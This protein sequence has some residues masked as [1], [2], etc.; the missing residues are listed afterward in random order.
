MNHDHLAAIRTVQDLGMR[1]DAADVAS[2]DVSVHPPF[3]DLRSVQTVLEDRGIP[4][5]LGA[6]HCYFEEAGAFTGE[7][8][9]GML[10]SLGVTYVIVGHSERRRLF[11]QTDDQV[12]ATVPQILTHGMVPIVCVGEDGA[13]R[14]SDQT[15]E[16]LTRQVTAA[17]EGLP[18]T[19]VGGLVVAYE[20][21]WAIG[22]GVTASAQDA[23]SGCA[24]VRS[25]VGS[26]SGAT[27]AATVRVLYG[28]S[29]TPDTT[30]ELAACDDVDGFLVGGASLRAPEFVSIV[31]A[32]APAPA[33]ARANR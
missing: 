3:V 33:G 11:G 10:E 6:Q 22:T 25:V 2:V 26:V 4:V 23:Q 9:P 20:P 31:R 7:V 8:S 15:E 30:A 32:A 28:G 29:V 27:A 21:V 18:G 12:R 13:E 17:L 24:H 14:E 19:Q 16:V 5:A 1:L